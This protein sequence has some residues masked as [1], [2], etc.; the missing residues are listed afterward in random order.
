MSEWSQVAA[1]KYAKKQADDQLTREL[2]ANK[3]LPLFNFIIE[4]FQSEIDA[5]NTNSGREILHI[6]CP[7]N[8]TACVVTRLGTN[9]TLL[10]GYDTICDELRLKG[11]GG[12]LFEKNFTFKAELYTKD[13][14]LV[15][16]KHPINIDAEI[17]ASLNA[18]LGI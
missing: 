18:I 5:F 2:I 8:H 10:I 16:D 14:Y 4:K 3:S 6:Q 12:V 9:S 7:S 15:E 1:S 17:A 13:V 11:E